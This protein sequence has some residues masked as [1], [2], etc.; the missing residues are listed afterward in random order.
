MSGNSPGRSNASLHETALY[1]FLLPLLLDTRGEKMTPHQKMMVVEILYHHGPVELDRQKLSERYWEFNDIIYHY[2][3][4]WNGWKTTTQIR[5][6]PHPGM[7]NITSHSR[8]KH[9]PNHGPDKRLPLQCGN[10]TTNRRCNGRTGDRMNPEII[11]WIIIAVL[12]LIMG[13]QLGKYYN[14]RKGRK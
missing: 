12:G 6:L 3:G 10:I 8:R 1:P 5:P 11:Y 7:Q 14:K 13:I 9:R 4:D 2:Q